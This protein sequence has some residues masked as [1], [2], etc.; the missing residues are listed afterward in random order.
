M[1]LYNFYLIPGLS[2]SGKEFHP[3]FNEDDLINRGL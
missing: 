2:I 1:L 3:V